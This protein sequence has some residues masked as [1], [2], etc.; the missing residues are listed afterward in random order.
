M[1]IPDLINASFELF[2]TFFIILNIIKLYNDKKVNG[3][4]WLAVM[5]FTLWGIW[6]LYYYPHLGQW[7]SLIGGIGIAITNTI[8]L[9][10]LIYYSKY[11]RKNENNLYSI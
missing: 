7:A 11:R 1:Q 3:V 2:G 5:Y 10:Q 4:S 9:G 6:N 8:W